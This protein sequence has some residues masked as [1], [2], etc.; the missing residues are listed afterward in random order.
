M[1]LPLMATVTAAALALAG[2][3]TTNTRTVIA[4]GTGAALGAL[5]ADALADDQAWTVVGAL[6][7]AAAG[8]VVARSLDNQQNCAYAVGDG[9]Y[10]VAPCP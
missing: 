7:G 6:A 5:T 2:C 1:K 4:G 3:E 9:T 8:T 10:R